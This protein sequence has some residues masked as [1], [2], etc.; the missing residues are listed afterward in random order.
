MPVL[1]LKPPGFADEPTGNLDPTLRPSSSALLRWHGQNSTII[2]VTH[3]PAIAMQ[4]EMQMELK[5]GRL[6]RVAGSE[7]IQ[8]LIPDGASSGV[9]PARQVVDVWL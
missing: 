6:H 4:A 8:Q 3:D 1:L 9:E 5:D 7:A 2:V